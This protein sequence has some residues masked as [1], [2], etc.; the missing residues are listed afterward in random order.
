L[1]GIRA[2]WPGFVVERDGLQRVNMSNVAGY[3]RVP[4]SIR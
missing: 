1:E 4:V 3:S 2:R